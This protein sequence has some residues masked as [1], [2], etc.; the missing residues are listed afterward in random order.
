MYVIFGIVTIF[1]LGISLHFINNHKKNEV[2]IDVGDETLN[3]VLAQVKNYVEECVLVSLELGIANF[4]SPNGGYI[5]PKYNEYYGDVDVVN[6]IEYQ[7]HKVPFWNE[8]AKDI[9]LSFESIE[10]KLS[11]FVYVETM[12]C[13]NNIDN[14]IEQVEINF[15]KI[16][17]IDLNDFQDINLNVQLNEDDVDVFFN[18]PIIIIS[19]ESETLI[20]EFSATL[21]YNIKRNFELAK[22]IL[23][24]II[25]SQPNYYDIREN[26]INYPVTGMQKIITQ[27]YTM[28][29]E[30]HITIVKIYDYETINY[31]ERKA[32]SLIFAVKNF[33]VRG[34]CV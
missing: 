19:G 26:C 7:G 3:S 21:P 32:I 1:I 8:D 24:E 25:A 22:R 15:A 18:L 33:N 34:M 11:N 27:D 16:G 4:T 29:P 28:T 13:I 14:E 9:S 5:D 2:L 10:Q 30:E 17:L 31:L 20:N 12:N 23:N 6:Y